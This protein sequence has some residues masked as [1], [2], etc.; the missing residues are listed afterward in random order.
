MRITIIL[1]LVG[2]FCNLNLNG[3]TRTIIGRVISEDLEALPEVNIQNIDT[4]LLGKTD[5]DGRFK[6]NIP[7]KTDKILFSWIGME[8]TEIKLQNDCDTLEVVMMYDAIYDFMSS[9]KSDRLRKKRFNELPKHHSDAVK[10]GLFKNYDICYERFFKPYKPAL[11]SINKELK[12]KRK[13]IK[14]TYKALLIGDTIRIPYSG[15]WRYDGTDRTTLH[16]YSYVVDGDNFDCI[17]KGIITEKNKRKGGYNIVYR[18][19]DCKDCRFDNIVLNKKELKVG[20]LI[21]YNMRYLKILK[22]K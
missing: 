6:I 22:D 18:V 15:D 11:D 21:E 19:I 7:Q 16:S 9:K 14:E 1:V 10:K 5:I 20:E 4:L 8:W 17:I 13:Q 12:S 3:Q 2:L